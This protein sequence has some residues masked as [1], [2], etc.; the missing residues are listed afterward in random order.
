[1]LEVNSKVISESKNE[2]I[3]FSNGDFAIVESVSDMREGVRIDSDVEFVVLAS[4]GRATINVNNE[5]VTVSEGDFFMS[6]RSAVL[7]NMF[8]SIDFSCHGFVF[9]REYLMRIIP[10]I[11]NAWDAKDYFENTPVRHLAAEERDTFELYYN[12]LKARIAVY[13]EP[14]TR[15]VMNSLLTA[16]IFDLGNAFVKKEDFQVRE[17]SSST[18][19]SKRFL[20]LLSESTPTSRRVD[21]Y[22]DKLSI[23]PKYLSA[24]CKKTT[25]HTASFIIDE[26]VSKKI[27]HMLVHTSLSIKEIANEL[28]FPSIYFFGKYVKKNLGLSPR[29]YRE[30]AVEA[31]KG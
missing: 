12:L 4:S 31:V 9:K 30:R 15:Q 11:N 2:N 7:D 24:V 21:Y 1:M 26:F 29:Q 13:N 10:L 28:G 25:G 20:E 8:M 19:I 27:S 14:F 3:I 22:A 17:F 16:L 23:T 18:N 5:A 6:I